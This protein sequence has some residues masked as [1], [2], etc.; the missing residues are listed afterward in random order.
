[1]DKVVIFEMPALDSFVEANHIADAW[2][3]Y[4]SDYHFVLPK[5][6][7]PYIGQQRPRWCVCVCVSDIPMSLWTH[8]SRTSLLSRSAATSQSL[9]CSQWAS[10]F[11]TLLFSSSHWEGSGHRYPYAHFLASSSLFQCHHFMDAFSEHYSRCSNPVILDTT[12]FSP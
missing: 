6:P 7:G 4:A 10:I 3:C 11:P 12:S 9:C 8:H 2:G 5:S 1:M